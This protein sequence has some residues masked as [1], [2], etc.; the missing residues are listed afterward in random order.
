[1]RWIKKSLF[2]KLALLIVFSSGIVLAI[3]MA[4]SNHSL[5]KQLI[6]DQRNYYTSLAAQ[7]ALEIDMQFFKAQT[8][9]DQAVI[10]FKTKEIN[11][12]NSLKLLRKIMSRNP[13]IG[14]SA[15][16]LAH[17]QN[18]KKTGF[19]MLYSWRKDDKLNT[20]DRI[21]PEQDYKSDWFKIPYKEKTKIWTAPYIDT[22]INQKM[23]TYS[24]PVSI[25]GKIVAIIT[26]DLILDSVE[27]LLTNLE[28][29]KTGIPVLVTKC[30]R[31]V[32]HPNKEWVLKETLSSISAKMTDP[33][34][35]ETMDSIS[36]I[37][38]E[39]E[40][41]FLRFKRVMS[42]EM[43]WLYF[44]STVHTGW[45]LGF[46]IP[47]KEILDPI[48]KLNSKMLY[49]AILGIIALLFPAF[50]VSHSITR[51]LKSLCEA[52]DQ[53]ALGNFDAP[54]PK[55][56]KADEIGRLVQDF[57][58]MRIDLKDYIKTL[59]STTAEKEKIASE[60]SIAKEI[61][62]G[63]LPK[64]FPPFPKHAG[65]DIF[66]I[67][68]SA[69][70]VGGDL[71]DFSMLD[72]NRLYICIGDVSG[73]GIPASLFMAVG[74]TLLKSTIL[75]IQDPAKAL[76]HVNNE[77]AENNDA[78]M[79]ITLFCGI[80]DLDTNELIYAN[81]GHNPPIII[82]GESSHFINQASAPPLGALADISFTNETIQLPRAGKFLLYTDGVT[83]AMN[84]KQELFSD[85]RLLE[86]M[87]KSCCK[88]AEKCIYN[89]KNSVSA[90]T[91]DAEQSDDI[92]M[93][94]ISNNSHQNVSQDLTSPTTSIVFTNSK[95]ELPRLTTWLDEISKG[96]NWPQGF[97]MQLNLVLE[98][99][100]VNIISY[101]FDDN[102]IHEIEV[103]L[104]QQK[105]T[106]TIHVT[107]NGTAF[108]PTKSD[109]ADLSTPIEERDIGGLG[110][111][112]IQNSLDNFT[113]ERKND[114]NIVIMQ[115]SL[116]KK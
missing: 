39:K 87:K 34:D 40:S 105:D 7:S 22:D 28:L 35:K 64:L 107:D 110:I 67:L 36:D 27:A 41:G 92:T 102:E 101:A 100:I 93:L 65:L 114:M 95:T 42:K 112:F 47:E 17:D 70:E 103:R 6:D 62:H 52:A 73:K 68:D 10:L 30:G 94:C 53:L 59:A 15:I 99:W 48:H 98:E 21:S 51:H 74:K 3:V 13:H 97:H 96:L 8:V 76:H 115:K 69:K 66:A 4:V 55:I 57:D 16:A 77:L 82:Q 25:D 113:Y 58:R 116:V 111:H 46:I 44:D 61:Q 14:G 71:Y 11:R 80:L 109:V 9:V 104:W 49:I 23:V 5:R 2:L 106:V 75:T 86:L 88:T 12:T 50:F 85:N 1:M 37:L 78:C 45:K 56:K 90:F 72:N 19:Q 60:L 63:I 54:L 83:E 33:A 29:G 38:T 31:M 32:S 81:A 18:F 84:M 79:F 43:A 26:C 89:I 108:D 24:V 91:G 20:S